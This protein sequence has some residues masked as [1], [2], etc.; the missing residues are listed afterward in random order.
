M[1][2]L[3]ET[4]SGLQSLFL[5]R[6]EQYGISMQ[7]TAEQDG[8]IRWI[9]AGVFLAC[10]AAA[11]S[12]AFLM[13]RLFPA[14]SQAKT[15]GTDQIPWT[16]DLTDVQ[17]DNW[18]AFSYTGDLA[19]ESTGQGV[20]SK[21][22]RLA[23]TFFAFGDKQQTRKAIIDDLSRHDQLMIAEG[24]TIGG[25]VFVVRILP[26]SIQIKEGAQEE[27]LTLSF[28]TVMEKAVGATN[29]A[30]D[31]GITESRFAKMVDTNRWVCN[32]QELEKYYQ[33]LMDHT[34]RLASVFSSMK[35][36]YQQ[37]RIAGYVLNIEGEGDFFKGVGLRENDVIRKVNSMP[38]TSQT[39]AEYFIREF[40]KNRLNAFVL[41]V[42]REGVPQKLIY[43][44]R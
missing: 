35:P 20:L 44:I 11:V 19:Q 8:L 26:E 38:M 4:K 32:R 37:N 43:M 33:E 14:D 6:F 3:R 12:L 25:T 9:A 13:P 1:G 34:D 29:S 15:V 42:E 17:P 24:E 5:F 21:R 40:S 10:G 28:A 41:E 16:V 27:I 18:M 31:M 2:I 39:R 30:G 22:F 23:G 36:V 7:S